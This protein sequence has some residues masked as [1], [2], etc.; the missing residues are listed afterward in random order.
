M[1]RTLVNRGIRETLSNQP[2]RFLAYNNGLTATATR[3]TIDESDTTPIIKS[4]SDLQIVNGGQTTASVSLSIKPMDIAF[5]PWA[6]RGR[7][8][9]LV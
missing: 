4:I 2:E 9:R 3:V 6:S 5:R 7:I 8:F 1:A